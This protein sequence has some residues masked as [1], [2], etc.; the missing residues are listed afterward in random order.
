VQLKAYTKPR[1]HHHDHRS[2]RMTSLSC[3]AFVLSKVHKSF[4]ECISTCCL[5]F[6]IC[7][8]AP[9]RH[10]LNSGS[11]AKLAEARTSVCHALATDA[12][13]GVAGLAL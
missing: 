10:V 3:R 11:N 2:S 5:W 1:M 9:D 8:V 6:H 7:G 12:I 4:F 13:V